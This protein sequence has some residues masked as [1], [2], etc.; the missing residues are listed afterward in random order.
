MSSL[1]LRYDAGTLVLDG[2]PESASGEEVPPGCLWDA[3]IGRFRAPGYRYRDVFAHLTR[4]SRAGGAALVDSARAY[5]PLALEHRALRTAF[6]HQREAVAAW[7][8]ADKRGV[9]VLPTGSGKSYV[10]ELAILATQRSTLIVAP[11]LDLMLQWHDALQ[12]AFGIEVGLLGGGNHALADVTVTTYDSAYLQMDR[13]GARFGLLVF[14]ECHHLPSPTYLSA[15]EASLAPYRLG[16]TATPD[17]ADGR[18]ALLSDRVG[19]VVYSRSIGDLAGEFLADYTVRRIEVSLTEAEAQRYREQRE[20]YRGFVRDHHIFMGGPDGWSRFIQLSSRSPE[21]RRALQAYR[22][23]KAI[24]TASSG[25]LEWLELLLRQHARDRALVF[26]N[27]NDTVYAISRAF[28]LPALTHQT[29]LAERKD[30]LTRFRSGEYPAVVTSKVLNEGVNVPEANV[31]IVLS[32]SGSVREHVQR[33][34]RI[35]RRHGDK[36]AVL[37]EVITTNTNEEH[38]SDR[39]REHEAYRGS[40]ATDADP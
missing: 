5:R 24:A 6:A 12:A 26:A 22:E 40:R 8:A 21:G 1:T 39:R 38:T 28:L 13:L 15:A 33:L 36:R 3:R 2:L 7:T 25:K 10:A 11:T 30:I 17:R 9:I 32:G 37:Y 23:Q 31:A 27:D 29:D 34:G 4:R 16:L 18:E 20:V 19:P 14:D 35:L